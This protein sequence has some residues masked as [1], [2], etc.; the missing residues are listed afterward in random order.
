MYTGIGGLPPY[1]SSF[2]PVD[3][4]LNYIPGLIIGLILVVSVLT[5]II[6]LAT[7]KC[8]KVNVIIISYI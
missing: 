2:C 8:R 1:F 6:C 5:A 3:D 4:F 7:R